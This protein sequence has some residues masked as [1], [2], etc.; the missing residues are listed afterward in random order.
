[1]GQ[2]EVRKKKLRLFLRVIS[3]MV[4]LI[5]AACGLGLGVSVFWGDLSQNQY[6]D[7]IGGM[8]ALFLAFA[9]F[10]LGC[11]YIFIF[12]SK[13][14]Y[15][16]ACCIKAPHQPAMILMNDRIVYP[17]FCKDKEI[18]FEDVVAFELVDYVAPKSCTTWKYLIMY[19]DKYSAPPG[20][21]WFLLSSPELFVHPHVICIEDYDMKADNMY[22]LFRERLLNHGAEVRV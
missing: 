3:Y 8:L 6:M 16:L 21:I 1:M 22:E 10:V 17:G 20:Y 13:T 4:F 18:Y 5:P 12:V 9:M 14:A 19:N 15:S 2:I 7:S 11:L